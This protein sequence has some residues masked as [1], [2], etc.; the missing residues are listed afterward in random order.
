[1][2]RL[3]YMHGVSFLKF[4]PKYGI[5]CRHPSEKQTKILVDIDY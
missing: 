1:M 2:K 4:T 3:K 5:M